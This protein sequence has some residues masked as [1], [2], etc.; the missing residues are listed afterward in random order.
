MEENV[1]LRSRASDK[2]PVTWQVRKYMPLR[3]IGGYG[4]D[5]L[6]VIDYEGA[7]HW[8]RSQQFSNKYYCAV[9]TSDNVPVKSGPSPSYSQKYKELSNKYE[10][11][12]FLRRDGEW[13]EIMDV[14]GD[15][16]WVNGKY[17][18]IN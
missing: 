1:K 9:I 2:A 17:A 18:W 15:T 13:L 11:Y 7:K 5:W 10:T 8:V 14:Y 6:K 12:R 4:K 16:G 3:Q